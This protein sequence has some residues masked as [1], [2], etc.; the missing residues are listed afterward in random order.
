MPGSMGG[1]MKVA[2]GVAAA[3]ALIASA[4]IG[5]RTQ[6]KKDEPARLILDKAETIEFTTDE[7]TWMSLDVS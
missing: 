4:P 2:L 3:A 1:F 7:G 5:V 6:D